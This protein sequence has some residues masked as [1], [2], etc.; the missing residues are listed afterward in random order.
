M[1]HTRAGHLLSRELLCLV[2]DNAPTVD[3]FGG[4]GGQALHALRKQGAVVIEGGLVRLSPRHLSPDGL[5]FVWGQAVFALDRD[6]AML[7]RWGPEGPPGW[8]E[9]A[10]PDAAAHGGGG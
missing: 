8:A 4:P 7:V 10:E 9:D 3:E 6:E 5:R 1:K 2:R